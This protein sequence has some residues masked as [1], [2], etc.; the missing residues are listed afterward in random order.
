MKQRRLTP[1][2]IRDLNR[3]YSGQSRTFDFQSTGNRALGGNPIIA[4][5]T[6]DYVL[7]NELLKS[8]PTATVDQGTILMPVTEVTAWHLKIPTRTAFENV[9]PPDTRRPYGADIQADPLTVGSTTFDLERFSFAHFLDI[10]QIRNATAPWVQ[11]GTVASA[12]SRDKVLRDADRRKAAIVANN[13]NFGNIIA[14]G[15]WTGTGALKSDI[16][17]AADLLMPV[18]GV[19]IDQLS[20]CMLN[21]TYELALRDKSFLAA[22]LYTSGANYPNR[23]ELAAYL[24][25]KE[26]EVVK[27]ITQ[28]D[29]ADPTT[30]SYQ[31]P[32]AVIVQYKGDP[33]Q[34][35]L[36][37]LGGNYW[38]RTFRL[39]G[40]AMTPWYENRNTSW[41]YPYEMGEGVHLSRVS[42][43]VKITNPT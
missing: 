34:L 13:A 39:P 38:A 23:A 3:L 41:F 30:V 36:P 7:T 6:V 17:A 37:E 43:A 22:R 16:E 8:G 18:T 28:S 14:G 9:T 40:A 11:L 20:V 33:S 5:Q 15:D 32:N 21:T 19:S 42:Y 1:Q 2:M 10:D 27:A 25:V 26:V 31:Y 35:A 12:V 4:T 29:P 24:G